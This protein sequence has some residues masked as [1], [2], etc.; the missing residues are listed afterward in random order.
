MY[1]EHLGG[2]Q[3]KKPPCRYVLLPLMA[4][5]GLGYPPRTNWAVRTESVN[6]RI[7]QDCRSYLTPGA[8]LSRLGRRLSSPLPTTAPVVE[9]SSGVALPWAH[10]QGQLVRRCKV[11][12]AR[13]EV[14]GASVCA[15][16]HRPIHF[17]LP[18]GLTVAPV[19]PKDQE[20]VLF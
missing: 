9:R 6:L 5:V 16:A 8:N 15:V 1:L 17:L 4:K 18:R 7:L 20:L 13:C 2:V 10:L 19:E 12:G 3:L 14:Q 11:R